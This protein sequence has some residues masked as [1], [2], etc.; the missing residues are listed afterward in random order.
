MGLITRRFTSEELHILAD[1][2]DLPNPLI[3]EHGYRAP[4]IE[5]MGLICA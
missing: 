5:A 4:A 1:A 2:L 3:T